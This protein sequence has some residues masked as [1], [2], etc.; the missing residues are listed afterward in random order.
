MMSFRLT[1]ST[2]VVMDETLPPL[3]NAAAILRRDMASVLTG[4][5]AR[6]RIILRQ[7]ASIAPQSWRMTVTEDEV[8]IRHGDALGGVYA[9]LHISCAALGV[10]PLWFWNDQLLPTM[11]AAELPCGTVVA[12][13]YAV[14]Y[15]GW[16]INDEVLLDGWKQSVD[17]KQ[18]VWR[19][20]FEALLRCGGNMIIPG[21][22]RHGDGLDI[23]ASDMGLTLTQHHAELLGAEMFG[24]RW[25]ELKG[26]YRLY[27]EKFE[28]LWWESALRLRGRE[29]IYAIGFRGQGD[30]PFWGEDDA[31]DTD[32]KRGAEVSRIMRRQMEIVRAVEPEAK[33][34][35]NLYG[36]M[37][38]LYR[39]GALQVPDGVVKIW[40]DNGYGRML[41][42]RQGRANP[43][44]DAMPRHEP[45]ENGVYFHAGF[46]DLQAANHITQL[47]IPPQRIAEEL[48]EI[49]S[50]GADAYWI[51]NCGSIKP[52]LYILDLIREA[53]TSGR[54][55]AVSHAARY[56]RTYL[57]AETAAPL[58]TGYADC[59]VAYGSHPDDLAGDQYYHHAARL[60]GWQLMRGVTA[61][62]EGLLWAEA[63]NTVF[64]QARGLAGR[65]EPSIPRWE[66]YIARC[67]ETAAAMPPRGA[68][69]LQ[70][71]LLMN[72]QVHLAGCR[73]LVQLGEAFSAW[74]QGAFDRAFLRTGDALA[75][76]REGYACMRA[77][78]HDGWQH[79]YGNDC[80]ANLRLTVDALE[81]LR[82]WIRT[83]H[84]GPS[85]WGWERKWLMDPREV[86]ICLQTHRH[87]QLTDEALYNA[88]KEQEARR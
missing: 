88:M 57:G 10:T 81:K 52:H 78:E 64:D 39:V 23:L 87:C 22:D 79:Y 84:D 66:S 7:D 29:V 60:L 2:E 34:C 61:P 36:E 59:A 5:G 76:A 58:L 86:R 80:F 49:Y 53:W 83:V 72:A 6:N 16:F 18:L 43:R 73:M 82:G 74:E 3:R 19:M 68:R 35:T 4:H 20:A 13:M 77:A 1:L 70:D 30:G 11:A 46:Y 69:L 67:R 37:M 41:S 65:C 85:Y 51:I 50:N 44:V 17:E 38:H 15:R 54:V 71:T 33:F 24:R 26:S 42:R 31:F 21:T 12:P 63:G 9:L 56:A 27:P 47:Q 48:N 32:E 75:A 14:R 25:P 55:D 62:A 45:G 28:Q 8:D 40:A